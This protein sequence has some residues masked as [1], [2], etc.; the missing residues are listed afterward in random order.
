MMVLLL[1]P[2]SFFK[3]ATLTPQR[4]AILARVSPL[5]TVKGFAQLAELARVT[6]TVLLG[7]GTACCRKVWVACALVGAMVSQIAA[8]KPHALWIFLTIVFSP[9]ADSKSI[10]WFLVKYNDLM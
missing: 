1:K 5:R 7:S 3:E 9:P 6:V 8:S 10:T 4:W 2:F